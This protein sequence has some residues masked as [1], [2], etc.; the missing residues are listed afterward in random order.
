M[1]R[2]ILLAVLVGLVHQSAFSQKDKKH[3]DDEVIESSLD[4]K[5]AC[6]KDES[7]EKIKADI[8]PFKLDKISTKKIYYKSYDQLVEIAIPIYHSTAYK[9]II[10]LEGLPTAIDFKITDKPHKLSSAKV[11]KESTEKHLIYET[12]ADYTGTR[13]YVTL[14]IP[15]DKEFQNGVRNHGCVVLGSGYSDLDF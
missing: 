9:F 14:K 15:A 13:I 12:P 4:I 10:N 8:T 1:V 2:L 5:D 3:K 6:K 7:A 11:L